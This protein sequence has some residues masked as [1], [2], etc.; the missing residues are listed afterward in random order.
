[1]AQTLQSADDRISGGALDLNHWPRVI[2]LC[3]VLVFLTFGVRV[4][5]TAWF[6]SEL[7][8]PMDHLFHGVRGGRGI[9]I[10]ATVAA[11]AALVCLL[12]AV[13]ELSARIRSQV[14]EL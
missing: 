14:G 2:G 12:K 7:Y 6:P 8:P 5:V 4:V 10:C 3:F 1:M 11:V 13:K 9:G